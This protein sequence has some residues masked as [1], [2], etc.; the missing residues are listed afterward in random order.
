M[1]GSTELK[2]GSEF[3]KIKRCWKKLG[4]PL[5]KKRLTLE[6]SCFALLSFAE[7]LNQVRFSPDRA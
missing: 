7:G 5:K 3:E 1:P 6:S 4:Q 2:A